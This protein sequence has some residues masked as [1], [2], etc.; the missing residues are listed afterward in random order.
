[1]DSMR[2]VDIAHVRER[3]IHI[4]Y[5]L[6]EHILMHAI[7][8]CTVLHIN[9]PL[10]RKMVRLLSISLCVGQTVQEQPRDPGHDQPGAGLPE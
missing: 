4:Q 2:K 7:A 9:N 8:L 10:N 6:Y 5:A 1:M 3:F